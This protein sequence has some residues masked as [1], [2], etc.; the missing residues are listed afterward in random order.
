M[1]LLPS[2]SQHGVQSN[3][4]RVLEDHT[5]AVVGHACQPVCVHH[6]LP[7]IIPSGRGQCHGEHRYGKKGRG[8]PQTGQRGFADLH[9]AP[10]PHHP[11]HLAVQAPAVQISARNGVGDDLR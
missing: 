10:H 4:P 7:S 3:C 11:N 5:D 8:E 6:C 9:P 1:Q 2:K